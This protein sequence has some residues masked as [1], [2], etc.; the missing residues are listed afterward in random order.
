MSARHLVTTAARPLFE[1]PVSDTSDSNHSDLI[2]AAAPRVVGRLAPSPT[3][4]LHL[5]HAFAFLIAWWSARQSGGRVVLRLEDLDAARSQVRF[6]DQCKTDLRWLG[7][8]WDEERLQSAGAGRITRAAMDLHQ[9]RLA[10]PC[11][12]SRADIFRA[13]GAPQRGEAETLYPGTCRGRHAS[14]EKAEQATGKDAGLR[15]LS[16]SQVIQ[17]D[18]R[19]SGITRENPAEAHGDFLILRRNRA[20]CYQLAVVVDDAVDGVTEVIRGGD[21]LE[22][23]ARQVTLQR[24]LGYPT[25]AYCHLPLICDQKGRRLA[26][27]HGDLSLAK[28][29]EEGVSAE[30]IVGWV[31]R[32]AQLVPE[33]DRPVARAFIQRFSWDHLSADDIRLPL[34]ERSILLSR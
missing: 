28:L 10:Y 5:G 27:R 2:P 23:T 12:C 32:L 7:L 24:A 13:A 34:D 29:R 22:S 26:K 1:V 3:G 18:D 25:P 11:T 21:L 15:F 4:E 20:P 33:G 16:S 31:A 30:S 14:L 8:D 9:R 17:F 19:V 6:I